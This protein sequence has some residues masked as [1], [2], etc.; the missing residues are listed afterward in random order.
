M[1]DSLLAAFVAFFECFLRRYP[2]D[3]ELQHLGEALTGEIRE[4]M[5]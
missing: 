3:E 2:H 1:S 5:Q 4:S